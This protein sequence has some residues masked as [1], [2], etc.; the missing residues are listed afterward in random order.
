MQNSAFDRILAQIASANQ[1]PS[2]EVR[3]QMQLAMELAMANP[4]PATQA[5]WDSI[6]KTGSKLT[7]DEFMAYLIEKNL[8]LP[9]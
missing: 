7:L 6:P 1:I 4:D 9:E 8:L 3:A 2:S 5:M